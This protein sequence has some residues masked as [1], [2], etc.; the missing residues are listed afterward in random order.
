MSIYNQYFTTCRYCGK[1]ILLTR[2]DNGKTIPCDPEIIRFNP[3]GGP[4][5]FVTETG[6]FL[7]GERDRNGTEMGY[8]K[9]LKGCGR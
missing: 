7:R 3:T 1:Q 5:T 8:K 2:A 9:H 4:D 6:R